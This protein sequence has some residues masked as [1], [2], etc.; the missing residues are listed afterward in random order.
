[1]TERLV[2]RDLVP[3]DVDAL[4]PIYGDPQVV[5]YIGGGE[6]AT[7]EETAAWIEHALQRNRLEGWD[8]RAV[9]RREDG[10]LLGRAGLG[11]R[12]IDGRSEHEVGYLLGREH[13]G[14]G[15]ATEAA[16]AVRDDA[17]E[18][19]G[20]RRLIALIDHGNDASVR[21]ATKL[22]MT[23]ERDVVFGGRVVRMFALED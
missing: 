15:Y 17:R 22:G 1:M 21:V 5:R 9:E 6:T 10:V 20:H 8:M 12:D 19:L 7:L 16:A 14:K 13:W 18:R 3:A 11:V 2:L 23:Y 4:A